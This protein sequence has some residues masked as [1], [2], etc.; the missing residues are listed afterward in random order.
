MSSFCNAKATHILS[1]K[2]INVFAIF[3]DR[4]FNVILAN[5]CAL[6]F[7]NLFTVL[8]DVISR[9]YSVIVVHPGHLLHYLMLSAVNSC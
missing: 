3:Q 4:N 5:N 7:H 2:N 6:V 9:L 1:A 8:L